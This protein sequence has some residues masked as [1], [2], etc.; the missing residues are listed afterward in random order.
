MAPGQGN[1]LIVG[2]YCGIDFV[3]QALTSIPDLAPWSQ[4]VGL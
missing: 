1:W 4:V 3:R 2:D